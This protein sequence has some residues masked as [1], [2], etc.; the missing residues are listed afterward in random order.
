MEIEGVFHPEFDCV[1]EVLEGGAVVDR[2][3]IYA[4]QVYV[5]ENCP[6]DIDGIPVGW[7]ALTGWTGQYGYKGAVMHASEQF[8][9]PMA[10]H[11]LGTPGVYVL[12]VVEVLE[13][14]E[15][16]ES[17]PAGWAVLRRG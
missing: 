17:E 13:E 12:V 8:A 3:D 2:H 1:F 7:E 9:G 5:Y 4:P 16:G 14:D 15:D 10:A 11:V 6:V